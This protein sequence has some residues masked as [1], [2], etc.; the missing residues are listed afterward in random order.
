[1]SLR[2]KDPGY[3]WRRCLQN[4]ASCVGNAGATI[5]AAFRKR[6]NQV[7]FLVQRLTEADLLRLFTQTLRIGKNSRPILNIAIKVGSSFESNWILTEESTVVGRIVSGAVISKTRLRIVI[8]RCV[9]I[10]ICQYSGRSSD[11]AERIINIH[12]C[13]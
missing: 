10:G 4:S 1:D 5:E 3:V 8:A 7:R 11:I 13:Q 9:L 2:E 12:V 6:P